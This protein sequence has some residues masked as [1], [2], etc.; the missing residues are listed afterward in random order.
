MPKSE[1]EIV[2]YPKVKHVKMLVNSIYSKEDHL[3]NDFELFLVLKNNGL[4]KIDG[5]TMDLHEG[6]IFLINSGDVHSYQAA[7]LVGHN[8]TP[9]D[10]AS[11]NPPLFLFVQISNHFIREYFPQ[12]RTTVFKSGNLATWMPE[13]KIAEMRK[14]LIDAA[15]DYFSENDN[16][17][18]LNVLS[19]LSKVLAYLYKYVEHEIINEGQKQKM[20]IKNARL[21]RIISYIDENF[22]SQIRLQDLADMENLSVTHFSHLFSS[23]FGVTFQEFVNL[24]RTEQ[25]IR[26]MENKEKT[27]LEISYESGFSD[28]KYMNKMLLKVYGCTPKEYRKSLAVGNIEQSI[29]MGEFENIYSDSQAY[30]VISDIRNNKE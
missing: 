2:K 1:I 16:E 28:P 10:M 7:K 26:L 12:I 8:I 20:K 14:L 30:N 19:N 27:L 13:E 23:S 29:E 11:V 21:E 17:A 18:T 24:K 5:K 15:Y 4:A 22:D 3:H 25:C 9:K 6:D